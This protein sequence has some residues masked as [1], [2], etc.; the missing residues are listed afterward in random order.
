MEAVKKK[1]RASVVICEL[2]TVTS[3]LNDLLQPIPG[4]TSE[5]SVRVSKVL[6][7]AKILYRTFSAYRQ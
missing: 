7:T 3:V 1:G 4:T 5:I 6:V 2:E